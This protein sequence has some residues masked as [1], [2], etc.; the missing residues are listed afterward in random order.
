MARTL[1]EVK[2]RVFPELLRVF[3][4][5]WKRRESVAGLTSH[6][7]SVSY[8]TIPPFFSMQLFSIT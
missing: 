6:K 1:V 4:G 7:L 2:L 8:H 5:P 3:E